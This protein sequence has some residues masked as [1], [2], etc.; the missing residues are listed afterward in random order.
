MA[1][2]D[3]TEP[4]L[5]AASWALQGLRGGPMPGEPREPLTPNWRRSPRQL[6][7][8]L[9]TLGAMFAGDF[10]VAATRRTRQ[11]CQ[12]LIEFDLLSSEG[13]PSVMRCFLEAEPPHRIRTFGVGR[14]VPQGYTV[15]DATI[16]DAP[17]LAALEASVPIES[18]GATVSV[19][20][21][22]HY[23]DH[24]KLMASAVTVAE[25][26]GEIVAAMAN[27]VVPMMAGGAERS[28]AYLH[29]G[30]IHPDHQGR[31]VSRAMTGRAMEH[32]MPLIVG[33]GGSFWLIANTNEQALA[34]WPE[35]S[36]WRVRPQ[37]LLFDVAELAGG[38]TG[39]SASPEDAS[40]IT[41]LI[42][43]CHE[44]EALF[45][46]YTED[47]LSE[48][49]TRVPSIYSWSHLR[50]QEGAV[51]GVSSAVER[52]KHIGPDG[53]TTE[54]RRAPILDF[55]FSGDQG[56]ARFEDLLRRTCAEL[57]GTEVTHL[58]LFSSPGSPGY[59]RLSTLSSAKE[60]YVLLT[61]GIQEPQAAEH[62]GVYI[63]HLYF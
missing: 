17:S 44:D 9:Q 22:S 61:L 52:R 32:D 26:G 24:M 20:R 16:A 19:D 29:H 58:T 37:R 23:W 33:D 11:P 21:G 47:R 46:P 60:T 40:R 8:L 38:S 35:E 14:P 62:H 25:Y 36:R 39:V 57:A 54:T 56:W 34:P 49:M 5:A 48:R 30:R 51:I 27:V 15:R 28:P 63:D 6:W 7:D 43:A 12:T 10:E 53:V 59:S 31:G 18:D 4:E 42:N 13:K 2:L 3:L 55:G 41:T 1:N 50:C 45:L